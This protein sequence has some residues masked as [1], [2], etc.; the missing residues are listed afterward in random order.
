MISLRSTNNFDGK[1]RLLPGCFLMFLRFCGEK[2]K[3]SNFF[4]LELTERREIAIIL[5]LYD[6]LAQLAEHLTFNQGV[7]SSN[8]QWVIPICLLCGYVR[9]WWNGRHARLRIWCPRRK[10]SSLFVRMV[11]A[12]NAVQWMCGSS[13]VGRAPPCQGGGR[14]SEPRLPLHMR[15]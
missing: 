3:F 6:S 8:L 1:A 10:S 15:V 2:R 12:P 9:A 13:S 4:I 11:F 5:K 7:W 14:G